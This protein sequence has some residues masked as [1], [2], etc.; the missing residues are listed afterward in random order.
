M[1][2]ALIRR[3]RAVA[4]LPCLAWGCTRTPQAPE[5]SH[6][7]P[8]NVGEAHT[9]DMGEW[10][11]LVGGTQPLPD[12][13]ARITAAVEGRVVSVLG[14]GDK[15]HVHEGEQVDPRQVLVRL[16]DSVIRANKEKLTET[17]VDLEEQKKQAALQVKQADIDVRQKE[18]LI[19]EARARN[20]RPPIPQVELDRA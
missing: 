14:D 11:D 3:L 9:V 4:L 2:P 20:E 1:R 8:V 17:V 10:T 15:T 13:A 19:D 12:K 16:D 6:P 5:E 18:K 7:A